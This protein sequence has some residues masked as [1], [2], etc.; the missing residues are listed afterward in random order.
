MRGNGTQGIAS[1]ITKTIAGT[2]IGR[3]VVVLVDLLGYRIVHSNPFK[4]TIPGGKGP[5]DYANLTPCKGGKFP[6]DRWVIETPPSRLASINA[7]YGNPTLD[8]KR[9]IQA[10]CPFFPQLGCKITVPVKDTAYFY[11]PE[12][13]TGC[14]RDVLKKPIVFI[15]GFDPTNSRGVK[16]IYEDY[17]NAQVSRTVNGIPSTV[18]FGD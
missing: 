11:F 3:I 6:G 15:D 2:A 18:L 7:L 14:K 4:I 9:K 8:Y 12:N 17:I 10:P 5:N 16:Q 1:F 13:G